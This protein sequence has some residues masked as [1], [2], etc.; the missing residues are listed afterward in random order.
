PPQRGRGVFTCFRCKQPGH[1]AADCPIPPLTVARP[2]QR[3]PNRG[4]LSSN[5]KQSQ[6]SSRD[7]DEEAV[8]DPMIDSACTWCLITQAVVDRLGLR[9]LQLRKPIRF[10]Q[11]DGSI[12]GGTP[13]TH[14]TEMVRM[15]MGHH[16]E[17][18][19]FVVVN[20]MTEAVILGLSWLDKWCPTIREGRF[21]EN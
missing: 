10:E 11:V 3:S 20:H 7:Q 19:S 8:D 12:L 9:L 13:A 16:W 1:R 17:K 21:P 14:R 18:I 4:M 2:T 6:E 15:D 5:L